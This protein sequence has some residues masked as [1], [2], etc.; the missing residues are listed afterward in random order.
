MASVLVL[1]G[2]SFVGRHIVESALDAGHDVTMFNRGKTNAELFPSV[3]RLAGDRTTG[4]YASLGDGEWDAVVDVC[5]YYPRQVREAATALRGR[6][7]H[8]TF[9]STV[10]V[11]APTDDPVDETSP[12]LPTAGV[13]TEEVTGETYGPLKVLCEQ[14]ARA[15]FVGATVVRPG[16]VAG[17]HDPTGRF[18]AW[19]R[20][21]TRPGPVL[22]SRPDAPVQVVHARDLADLTLRVTEQRVADTF[23][24]VGPTSGGV[25]MAEVL[26]ACVEAAE[27]APPEIVWVDDELIESREVPLPLFLPRSA[28]R[29]GLFR[30]SCRKAEDHGL[31]NR[32]LVDTARDTLDWLRAPGEEG[33]HVE[34]LSAELESE[35]LAAWASR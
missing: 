5:A 31:I 16:I 4:D 28:H 35:I 12:L 20:R 13:D 17:P 34:L 27:V 21:A 15:E 22:A 2:T 6:A 33:A 1:G 14:T 3:R 11:Y 32:P 8:Y 30:A 9:I 29:D 24:A 10:S 19:V 18:T 7:G 26:V 25:A 23:N